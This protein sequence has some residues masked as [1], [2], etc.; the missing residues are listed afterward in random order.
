MGL[1]RIGFIELWV[2]R[3]SQ[4]NPT[5]YVWIKRK[6][7]QLSELVNIILWVYDKTNNSIHV[8]RFYK[9]CSYPEVKMKYFNE[10]SAFI[11]TIVY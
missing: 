3:L 10:H 7:G 8:I 2:T 11:L 4:S 1:N 9:Q 5:L 6:N